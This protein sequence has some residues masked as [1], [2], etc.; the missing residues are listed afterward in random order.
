MT[1]QILRLRTI[2]LIFFFQL[3]Q[4]LSIIFKDIICVLIFFDDRKTIYDH[5][6]HQLVLYI[7]LFH[8]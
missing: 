7:L 8:D 4:K 5:I 6:L 3:H 1:W 2:Y